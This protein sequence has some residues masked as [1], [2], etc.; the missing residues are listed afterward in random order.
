MGTKFRG[1]A[2]ITQMIAR[3]RQTQ[4]MQWELKYMPVCKIR[5][6]NQSP[7]VGKEV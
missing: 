1:V 6:I 7:T 2:L 3:E 4:F 5:V